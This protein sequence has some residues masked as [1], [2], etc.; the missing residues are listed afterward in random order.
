MQT[1]QFIGTQGVLLPALAQRNP[2]LRCGVLHICLTQFGCLPDHCQ[3]P[4]LHLETGC[5]AGCA[6]AERGKQ[7][8]VVAGFLLPAL[9]FASELIDFEAQAFQ[10]V[11]AVRGD[12]LLQFIDTDAQRIAFG[13][14]ALQL[15]VDLLPVLGQAAKALVDQVYLQAGEPRAQPV[16]ALALVFDAFEQLAVVLALFNQG[17]QQFDLAAGAQHRF[18]RPVEIVDVLD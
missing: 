3:L 6:F 11:A 4:L 14:E 7:F 2:Q 12:C 9:A 10:T 16:A 18:V 1:T 15:A 17:M 13:I 5:I 8:A